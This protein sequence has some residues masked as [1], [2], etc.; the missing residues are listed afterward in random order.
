M[1]AETD[2]H[3]ETRHMLWVEEEAPFRVEP[4]VSLL[5]LEESGLRSLTYAGE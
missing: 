1:S 5:F 3:V 4:L 2:V